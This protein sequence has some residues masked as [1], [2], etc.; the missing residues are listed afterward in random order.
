MGKFCTSCG[1]EA[2][3]TMMDAGIGKV[4]TSFGGTV[5][6]ELAEAANVGGDLTDALV[7]GTV[8]GTFNAASGAVGDAYGD[9]VGGTYG[10]MLVKDSTIKKVA[11]TAGKLGEVGFEKNV[12]GTVGDNMNGENK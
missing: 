6:G 7:E 8:K 4:A 9:A 2:A 1:T 10:E 12:K 11:E 5:V 3:T